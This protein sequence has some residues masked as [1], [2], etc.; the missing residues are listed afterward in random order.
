M[1]QVQL[2]PTYAQPAGGL[3][4]AMQATNVLQ[5]PVL[6]P[7]IQAPQMMQPT[8]PAAVAGASAVSQPSPTAPQLASQA[9]ILS[10]PTPPSVSP[11]VAVA[12]PAASQPLT[13]AAVAESA[14]MQ[15]LVAAPQPGSAAPQ[16]LPAATSSDAKPLAAVSA[17]PQPLTPTA[18]PASPAAESQALPAESIFAPSQEGNPQTR[19]AIPQASAESV[20]TIIP[21]AKEQVPLAP[22]QSGV[23][24]A[25]RLIVEVIIVFVS[26][27][28]A[29]FLW[30]ARIQASE[31]ETSGF[32]KLQNVWETAKKLLLH[33]LQPV[34][35]LRQKLFIRKVSK[36]EQ[37]VESDS[38]TGYSSDA[39]RTPFARPYCDDDSD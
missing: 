7:I 8:Q 19:P 14:A 24:S 17:V 38:S 33:S 30:R 9:T 39:S 13:V 4:V 26:L 32:G 27:V 37:H 18:G 12:A 5:T 29:I 35:Q 6:Q 36:V 23:S 3:A 15:P 28:G 21:K 31:S 20:P 1:M 11:V 2:A 34:P 10:Q 16:S 25:I 22:A